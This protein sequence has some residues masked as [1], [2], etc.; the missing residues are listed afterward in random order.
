MRRASGPAV[1]CCLLGCAPATP[2]SGSSGAAATA[3]EGAVLLV[4]GLPLAAAEVEPLCRDIAELY[5]EYS[6]LHARRL[7]LTNEFL[8]RL[9]AHALDPERW[10][11]AREACEALGDPPRV[12][13]LEP[14]QREGRFPALGL[15][16]WSVAR[17][18]PEG[19]WSAPIE[20]TGR[21]LRLRLDAKEA[22]GD[23]LL[24]KLRISMLEFPYVDPAQSRAAIEGAIDRAHLTLIAPEFAEAVPEIWKHRM[25]GSP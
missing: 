20:L 12:E 5:P 2:E 18:L 22:P 4:D 25:R 23:P 1:L 24:E 9:A 21:W 14:L 15:P 17:H 13:G 19:Q 10:R 8:P 3:P 11:R 6:R 7:A 16:L